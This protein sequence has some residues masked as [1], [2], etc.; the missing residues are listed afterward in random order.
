MS[1]SRDKTDE[2]PPQP[3]DGG[4]DEYPSRAPDAGLGERLALAGA[5]ARCALRY[6]LVVFPATSRELRRWRRHAVR[7][8][9]AALRRAALEALGKRSN[10]EGA[11]AFAAATP[12]RHGRQVVRALVAFQMAY[13]YVDVLAE[14]PSAQPV[15]GARRLHEALLV[16]LDPDCPHTNYYAFHRHDDDGGYLA[17]M[18]DACRRALRT[19]PAWGA[20][21]VAARDS[22]ARIVAFQSLSLG[23][24]SE[25]ER[26]ARTLVPAEGTF[27]HANNAIV[28]ANAALTW[29]E[30]AAAAGSSLAVHALIAAAAMPTIDAADVAAIE[31]AYATWIGALHSLL[32]SAVDRDED[33]A[34]GQLSLLSC[35][36]SEHEAAQRMRLLSERARR[37]ARALP[38]GRRHVALVSAMACN[39][40][41]APELAAPDGAAAARAGDQAAPAA[42][43]LAAG[44]REA[45]GGLAAPALAI[46]RMRARLARGAGA[47]ASI[48]ATVPARPAAVLLVDEKRGVDARAA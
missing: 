20:V 8:P 46:F 33:A 27:D 42:S 41:S 13:N 35:Y 30:A 14:Q 47:D 4:L 36:G 12:G 39:Y 44:V 32:D 24:R 40:L 43:E 15:L 38:A 9:D 29:W 23:K 37:A 22:A 2:R 45:L 5:F 21:T 26:W 10:I 16:A 28:S 6:W 18:V 25:L 19:L 1:P 7:I 48:G 3:L 31:H 11:A 17:A 34:T